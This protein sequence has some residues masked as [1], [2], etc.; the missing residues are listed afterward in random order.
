MLGL[1]SAAPDRVALT[2]GARVIRSGGLVAFPTETFYGLGADALDA[3][4]VARLYRAKGRPAD[5]A[6]LVLVD[7]IAMAADLVAAIPDRVRE[8]MVRHWPGPL[9]IVLEASPAVPAALTGGTGTLGVRLPG[10]AAARG[11][12]AAAGR[13]VTAPSANP[14]G[15]AP[16]TTAAEVVRA[17]GAAVDLVLDGGPTAGGP[18]STIVDCTTWPPRIVRPGPVVLGATGS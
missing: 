2:A 8:L 17:L 16:P 11:L 13:P 5:K 12:V 18:A 7:S 3:A 15:A 6:V 14:H 4:A 10:H 1:G 9:T